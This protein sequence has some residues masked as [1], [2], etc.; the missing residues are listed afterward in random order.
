MN[1]EA[2]SKMAER[3][4]LDDALNI[5][6]EKLAFIHGDESPPTKRT[7]PAT[8]STAK[9]SLVVE[10]P[11]VQ[12]SRQRRRN[13]ERDFEVPNVNEVLDEV[14]VPLNARIPHRLMQSLRRL[15]FERKLQQA[16]PDSI[17]EF[18]AAALEDWLAKRQAK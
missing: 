4:S 15:H 1:E 2:K 14:L 16:K 6:P 8:A 7:Q 12:I 5:S 17:Q 18:V 10:T 13:S 9:S 11:H 3:R